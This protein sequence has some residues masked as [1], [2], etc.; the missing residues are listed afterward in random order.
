MDINSILETAGVFQHG[1]VP[2]AEVKFHDEVRK[3]CQDGQCGSYGITWACPPGVGTVDECRERCLQYDT[4]LVFSAKFDL[5]DSF[6]FDGMQQGMHD[7]KLVSRAIDAAVKPH[8]DGYL[9]LSNESCDLCAACTYPD[10]P[11]RFPDRAH[12]AIEGYGILVSELAGQAGMN[13]INGANTVT[14]FGAL[15]Y[16]ASGLF[17]W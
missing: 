5:E 13:Y 6:D 9:L 10:A 17:A 2:T 4:M 12:G 11:C 7:F 1:A 14:Y 8:L 15:L 16:N 3:M